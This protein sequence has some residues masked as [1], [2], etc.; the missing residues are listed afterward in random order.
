MHGVG[1]DE[2]INELIT[3]KTHYSIKKD[4]IEDAQ[5]NLDRIT[6]WIGNCDAKISFILAFLGAIFA[7]VFSDDGTLES[8]QSAINKSFYFRSW[9]DLIIGITLI[10]LFL[11]FIISSIITFIFLILGLRGRIDIK[12]FKENGLE[13]NSIIFWGRISKN[14]FEE[15]KNNLDSITE[16]SIYNDLVSQIYINSKICSLKFENYNKSL[17]YVIIAI[18]AIVLFKVISYMFVL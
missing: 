5:R 15:Y 17:K 1:L 4:K 3:K 10:V 16:E 11:L 9:V 6:N 8:I 12:V 7:L 18:I 13:T 14:N 2:N